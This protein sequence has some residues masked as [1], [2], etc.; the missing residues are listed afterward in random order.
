MGRGCILGNQ[1]AIVLAPV[2]APSECKR[3]HRPEHGWLYLRRAQALS[4][5]STGANQR[6]LPAEAF[7]LLLHVIVSMLAPRVILAPRLFLL[8]LSP[9]ILLAHPA[10]SPLRLLTATVMEGG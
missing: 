4:Y 7:P 9:P 6:R 2:A 1:G 8:L 5:K 10:M 3:P